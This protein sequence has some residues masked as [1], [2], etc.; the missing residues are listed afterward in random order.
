MKLIINE[1]KQCAFVMSK[2]AEQRVKDLH[3]Y[4]S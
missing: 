4:K 1:I 3:V 2:R